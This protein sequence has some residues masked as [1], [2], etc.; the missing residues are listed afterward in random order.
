MT[1][2][3]STYLEIQNYI[4]FIKAWNN[5]PKESNADKKDNRLD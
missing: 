5:C 2:G 4:I 3:F 1:L